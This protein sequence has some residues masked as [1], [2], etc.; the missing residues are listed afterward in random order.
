MEV[1]DYVHF[2]DQRD[3]VLQCANMYIETMK[4]YERSS[5]I[6]AHDT[7]VDGRKLIRKKITTPKGLEKIFLELLMNAT[8]NYIRTKKKA[9]DNN[10][11]RI[12]GSIY[13]IKPIEVCFDNGVIDIVNYGLPIP[14][15]KMTDN[16]TWLIETI[17]GRLNTSSNYNN[18]RSGVG[19]NGVGCKLANIFSH[20]FSVMVGDPVN[21]LSYFQTWGNNMSE[22]SDPVIQKYT[23]KVSFVRVQAKVD[24]AKFGYDNVDEFDED[25]I[26]LFYRRCIDTAYSTGFPIVITSGEDIVSEFDI[27]NVTKYLPYFYMGDNH[28]THIIDLDNDIQESIEVTYFDSD[29]QHVVSFVNGNLTEQHG[30]HVDACWN[31]VTDIVTILN[32]KYKKDGANLTKKQIKDNL[33]MIVNYRVL[34][35]EYSG[36]AK[37]SLMGKVT[38]FKLPETKV[39]KLLTWNITDRLTSII[40]KKVDKDIKKTDGKNTSKIFAAK[41]DD[42]I[43]AGKKMSAKDKSGNRKRVLILVEGDSAKGYANYFIDNIKDGKKYYGIYPMTGKIVN[44]SKNERKAQ[45]SEVIANIKMYLGLKDGVDYSVEANFKSLRYD[46][47]MILADQD[48]DGSHITMLV[49]NMFNKMFHS[50]VTRNDF[51]MR[52]ITPKYRIVDRSNKVTCLY[53]DHDYEVW[54]TQHDVSKYT[55][56]Y[57]K[58]LASS[59]AAEVKQDSKTP[60]VMRINFDDGA[61]HKLSLAF[62]KDMIKSRKEWLKDDVLVCSLSDMQLSQDIS[63]MV[64]GELKEYSKSTLWRALPRVIDG[65]KRSHLQILWTVFDTWTRKKILT[66]DKSQCERLCYKVSQFAGAVSKYVDY[67]HGEQSLNLGIINMTQDYTGTNNLP[68]FYQEGIFGTRK[69]NGEDCGQPRYVKVKPLWWIHYVY[70]EEDFEILEMEEGDNGSSCPK[71]ML[72]IIPMI[73]VNGA[74]GIA[75]G[76][77]TEIPGVSVDQLVEWLVM[78]LNGENTSHINLLPYFKGFK[79]DVIKHDDQYYTL[80]KLEFEGD[81]IIISE[82]PVSKSMKDYKVFLDRLM[83]NKYISDYEDYSTTDTPNF[84]IHGYEGSRDIDSLMSNLELID[85]RKMT[86]MNA[87]DIECRPKEYK[88]LESILEDY[89]AMRL[90]YY[91]KRRQHIIPKVEAKIKELSE[92]MRFIE[93]VRNDEIVWRNV[94]KP[95]VIEQMKAKQFEDTQFINQ[96]KFTHF[97]KEKIDKL[98]AKINHQLELL[99][100]Y[101]NISPEEM[102][103]EDLSDFVNAYEG[104]DKLNSLCGRVTTD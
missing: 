92:I 10:I 58:G 70:R 35:P 78:R 27:T 50:L 15:A 103:L 7:D 41:G 85:K 3:Q 48:Y 57:L 98:Q 29:I 44:P 12:K 87:L 6:L 20:E 59:T 67:H 53:C 52:M 55:V 34:N 90:V 93:L 64:D 63:S 31:A 104:E 76:V 65:L 23:E 81:K 74:S 86:N 82:I 38:K 4:Q 11:K 43:L 9:I 39:K 89:Y 16:E 1:T 71:F 14:V 96:V 8:D 56:K 91:E 100:K 36:Q 72:P 42:A 79:G 97:T 2:S 19:V 13:E 73:L 17:F 101:S 95:Q 24:L 83:M 102:W 47:V 30:T 22:I 25:T 46:E 45:K 51:I 61:D 94:P 88:T 37:T 5:T 26:G 49:I 66:T 77:S 80:G 60:Y 28:V 68:Y 32:N 54:K 40:R 62:D 99:D 18:E 75:T 21:K 69:E 84:H 33:S